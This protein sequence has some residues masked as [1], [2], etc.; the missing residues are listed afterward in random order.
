MTKNKSKL[1]SIPS[2]VQ[3]PGGIRLQAI[4]FQ[5]IER[6]VDGT[7][8]TFQ[9]MPPGTP[10]KGPD[11]LALFAHEETVRNPPPVGSPR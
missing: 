2:V 4:P 8:K 11:M 1:S 3:L 5:I 6:N 10:V 7:P 9:I